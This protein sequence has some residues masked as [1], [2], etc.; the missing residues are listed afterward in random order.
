MGH[1]TFDSCPNTGVNAHDRSRPIK[2]S[3]PCRPMVVEGMKNASKT[4][5]HVAVH[6]LLTQ[7]EVPIL[8]ALFFL[9]IASA[10]GMVR[11]GAQ[12]CVGM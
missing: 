1:T 9:K 7:S 12:S 3:D 2:S 11:V 10:V 5:Q 8:G 4:K 6:G